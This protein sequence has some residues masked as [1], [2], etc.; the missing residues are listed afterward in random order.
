MLR[1]T[2]NLS[3][4]FTEYPWP[5]RFK[6]AKDHG[7]QA[8]EIQFPYFMPAEQI[9]A[10]LQETG[11]R[12]VLF[13][14][15]ADTL[16]QGG[17]GLAAIPEKMP[18]FKIAVD[19]ALAYAELLK[20]EAINILPGRCLNAGRL[21]EYLAAFKKNLRYAAE[22]F[23]ALGIKT[24]FE[25]VNSRDMPG[26]II[27]SSRKMLEVLAEVDQ[28]LLGLQYDIYHMAM[29]GEDYSRFLQQH[30]DKVGHIQF[31]DCPGRGQPGT[32][33]VD[34]EN[35]FAIIANSAY[36]GWVGA[37]YRPTIDTGSSLGWLKTSALNPSGAV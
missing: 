32:G 24:V 26:Y 1:F 8:V 19:Q 27:D 4:L 17:E 13:N 30:S 20:P 23:A 14:V 15:D 5:E 18:Q 21:G 37:E 9:L 11:L 29:M 6:A 22:T 33:Q 7:F 2:A 31:A 35:L 36:Q 12:L 16:L 25:A 3:L 10:A 28:P 34:F